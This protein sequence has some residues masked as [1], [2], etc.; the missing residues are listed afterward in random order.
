MFKNKKRKAVN[1]HTNKLLIQELRGRYLTE[2][3]QAIKELNDKLDVKLL[4]ITE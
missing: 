1:E 4:I 3:K 2:A